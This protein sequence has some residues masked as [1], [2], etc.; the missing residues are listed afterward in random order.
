MFCFGI[1][2]PF[3]SLS[4]ACH[5]GYR[6]DSSRDAWKAHKWVEIYLYSQRSRK[7]YLP[8]SSCR[9]SFSFFNFLRDG[10]LPPLPAVSFWRGLTVLQLAWV[11]SKM[12]HVPYLLVRAPPSNKW[13][14]F[15]L[16]L[17]AIDGKVV[18]KTDIIP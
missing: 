16:I 6:N 13:H 5:A 1:K 4:N 7:E 8:V 15:P 9:V 18:L 12:L 10:H 3:P 11:V 2:L 17:L 14:I